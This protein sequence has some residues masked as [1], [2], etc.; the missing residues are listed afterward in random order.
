MIKNSG[1]VFA[2]ILYTGKDTKIMMNAGKYKLK[3]SVI[4]KQLNILIFL[5]IVILLC[6]D[7]IFTSLG[8]W[9]VHKHAL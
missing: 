2:M 9:W 4:E 3:K 6:L 7:A 8:A 5:N 1:K